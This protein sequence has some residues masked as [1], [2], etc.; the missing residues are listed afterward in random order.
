MK[1]G[2]Q[3]HFGAKSQSEGTI[4]LVPNREK[5]LQLFHSA[6]EEHGK[7]CPWQLGAVSESVEREE[8]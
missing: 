2:P 4:Q 6:D 3:T 7:E 5:W 8:G 1:L